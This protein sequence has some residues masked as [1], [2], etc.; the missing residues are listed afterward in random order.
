MTLFNGGPIIKV[1]NLS[2]F[3]DFFSRTLIWQAGP[4]DEVDRHLLED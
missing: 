3:S 1:A 4:W 2:G